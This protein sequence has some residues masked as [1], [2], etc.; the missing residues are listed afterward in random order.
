MIAFLQGTVL[1]SH[2]G[3]IVL[4]V[5][6]GAPDS[7]VGYLIQV[8]SHYS[9][10]G[11]AAFYIH[12]HVRE[13]ALDLYGFKSELEREVFLLLLQVN[14]IGPRLA[15]TILSHLSVEDLLAA[16]AN[17]DRDRLIALPGVGK[18]TVERIFIDLADAVE[19]KFSQQQ[20]PSDRG[21]PSGYA[22]VMTALK[23]LGYRENELD[24]VLRK[25]LSEAAAGAPLETLV[26]QTLRELGT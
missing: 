26:R 22:D 12:T 24:R 5:A 18:K 14:G 2:P 6:G 1:Q 23:S 8:P 16:I 21:Q 4:G 11:T 9:L 19:K 17:K 7:W 13:D 3:K 25:V 10:K 20:I 15:L